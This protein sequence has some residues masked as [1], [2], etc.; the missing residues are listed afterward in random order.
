[1]HLTIDVA[2][3]G[4]QATMNIEAPFADFNELLEFAQIPQYNL[5]PVLSPCS[6]TI[7]HAR[8]A[9]FFA[10]ENGMELNSTPYKYVVRVLNTPAPVMMRIELVLPIVTEG[11]YTEHVVEGGVVLEKQSVR[12][13]E[14]SQSQF[15]AHGQIVF[16]ATSYSFGRA[17]FFLNIWINE[18]L[19]YTSEEFELLARRNRK[20]TPVHKY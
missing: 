11:K 17:K 16:R 20:R 3:E 15:E 8:K 12:H 4:S 1:M 10:I 7:R 19:V 5:H 18:M 9:T 2:F 6:V 13:S 14:E